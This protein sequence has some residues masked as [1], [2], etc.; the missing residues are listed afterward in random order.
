MDGDEAAG[1][2]LVQRHFLAV[3]RFFGSKL[4]D[5][6]DDLTQATFEACIAGRDGY[7][8]EGAFRAFILGIARKQL[9]RHLEGRDQLVGGRATSEVSMEDLETLAQKLKV[10]LERR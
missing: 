8:A 4:P 3:Y 2:T 1:A 6:A 5:Q 7:R 9:L 10:A